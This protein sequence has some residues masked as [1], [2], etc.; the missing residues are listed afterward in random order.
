MR[1]LV[2][3]PLIQNKLLKLKIVDLRMNE[4]PGFEYLEI[5]SHASPKKNIPEMRLLNVEE[6]GGRGETRGILISKLDYIVTKH[7]FFM[8]KHKIE[9]F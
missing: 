4:I 9:A 5:I 1:E 6:G 3:T 7:T 2:P 8:Y